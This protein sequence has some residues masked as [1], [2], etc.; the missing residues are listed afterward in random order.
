M[1]QLNKFLTRQ[2]FEKNCKKCARWKI[3]ENFLFDSRLSLI[4]STRD[5]KYLDEIF[6]IWSSLAQKLQLKQKWKVSSFFG[7]WRR[8]IRREAQ[9]CDGF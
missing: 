6:L 9:R 8:I 3:D 4:T 1:Q 5:T 7:P 2:F